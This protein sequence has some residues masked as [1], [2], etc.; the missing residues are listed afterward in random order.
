MRVDRIIDWDAASRVT[1][2]DSYIDGLSEFDYDNSDQLL[3]ADHTSQTDE[4]YSFDD[5]GNRTMTGY[6]TGD[7]NQRTSDGT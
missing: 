1:A 4:S 7:N 6:T 3:D 2:I 5:I